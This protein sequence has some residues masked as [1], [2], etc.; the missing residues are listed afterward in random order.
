MNQNKNIVIIGCGAAGGTAAQFARKTDRKSKITVFEKGKYSQHS[1]CGL[2]YYISGDI[3]NIENLI[4]FSEDWFRKANIGLHLN[5]T[6][7]KIDLSKKIVSA[8]NGNKSIEKPYDSL[9]IA[10]GCKAKVPPIKNVEESLGNGSYVLR[11][12]TDAKKIFSE[13]KKAKKAVII[14]AGFIGLELADSLYKKGLEVI[15]IEAL[16]DILPNTLDTDM[17]SIL[18][19]K[20]P[21][22]ISFFTNYLATEINC[23][24]GKI[25]SVLIKNNETFKNKCF[26]A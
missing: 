22:N 19:E 6:V 20:I 16:S 15:V 1:K 14:G 10:T 9:I 7:E 12:I 26:Y 2:P 25:N 3:P 8:K 24:N 4:E 11:T 17:S 18:R 23:N 5:T 13:I 21:K